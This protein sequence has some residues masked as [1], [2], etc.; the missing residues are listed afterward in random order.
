[1][2]GFLL[3]NMGPLAM[4]EQGGDGPCKLPPNL[5]EYFKTR[6]GLPEDGIVRSHSENYPG[7]PACLI[8]VYDLMKPPA[9]PGGDTPL[10]RAR[11][12]AWAIVERE[13]DLLGIPDLT[14]LKEKE[15]V[16]RDE[17]IVI[18]YER[19]IGGVVLANMQLTFKFNGS[20][21]DQFLAT[22]VPV[23]PETYEAVQ[24]ERLSA[25]HIKTIV[26]QDL[27]GHAELSAPAGGKPEPVT[28]GRPPNLKLTDAQ[29]KKALQEQEQ[30]PPTSVPP[31]AP[32]IGEP[33]LQAL[34]EPPY[35]CW[36]MSASKGAGKAAFGYGVDA[37]SGKILSKNCSVMGIGAFEPGKTPCD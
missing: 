11:S 10:Q 26:T 30:K 16:V 35:L 21:L 22:L 31:P 32:K 19:H 24:R 34:T 1:M 9:N 28:T 8:T 23:P 3:A 13:K 27:G 25:A 2:L 36:V 29:I 4:A 20:I 17:L 7:T 15:P 5:Y 33:V 14:E 12:V 6:Y 18:G 37:F